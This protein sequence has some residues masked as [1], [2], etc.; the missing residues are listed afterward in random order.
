M[1]GRFAC[2][3]RADRR[4]L[5]CFDELVDPGR[6][7]TW[8]QLDE[9][10]ASSICYTSGTTGNPKGAVYSHR[11]T[12]LHAYA[13]AL[14]DAMN[15]SARDTILPVVPMFHVNAW[16]LPYMRAW[17][18]PSWCCP[19]RTWTASPLRAVRERGA[20]PSSAGVPTVW[21]GLHHLRGQVAGLKFS[22][23]KRTGDGGSACPPAMMKTLRT[24]LRRRGHPCLGHDRT[25]AAGTLSCSGPSSSS[26]RQRAAPPAGEA[27]RSS[28]ASTCHHRRRRPRTCP[29]TGKA[30]GNL[31]V[32]AWVI[33]RYYGSEASPLVSVNGESAGWF[34][35]ATWPPSTPT[36]SCRSPTAART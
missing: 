28:T 13:S 35:P 9:N 36:A 21:L 29:G 22:S 34:P 27:G 3:P 12:L 2:R 19:A 18:A 26:C 17:S 5:L 7:H 25:V 10:T 15:C 8:P 32:R 14:P 4:N 33:D 20:S 23:F 16:G 31:V 1:V 11:S 6:R 24:T 30:A